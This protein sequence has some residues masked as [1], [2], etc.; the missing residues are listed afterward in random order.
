MYN[1]IGSEIFMRPLILTGLTTEKITWKELHETLDPKNC[2]IA[3]DFQYWTL[4]IFYAT[5][6]KIS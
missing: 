4:C 2:V 3:H 5:S 6:I 1:K